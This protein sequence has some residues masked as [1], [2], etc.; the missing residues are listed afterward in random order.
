MKFTKGA[1]AHIIAEEIENYLNEQGEN[2]P[3]AI[4]RRH[5]KGSE[6]EAYLDRLAKAREENPEEEF[7]PPAP[8]P[9]GKEREFP[10]SPAG[11]PGF[12][13]DDDEGKVPLAPTK[14]VPHLKRT[15]I[16]RKPRK[17]PQTR[18]I[19]KK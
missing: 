15:P 8:L 4:L 19:N 13:P 16:G 2:D 11:I 3:I 5:M 18:F 17:S 14:E 1:L 10:G 6:A 9:P 7:E 12:Q